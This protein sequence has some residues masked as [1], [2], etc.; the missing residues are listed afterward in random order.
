MDALRNCV[1]LQTSAGEFSPFFSAFRDWIEC[2]QSCLDDVSFTLHV[3]WNIGTW[4][5]H[6]YYHYRDHEFHRVDRPIGDQ[7]EHNVLYR[8]PPNANQSPR[9][10]YLITLFL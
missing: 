5:D 10:T 9:V 1:V 6:A 8:E 4:S 2:N 3:E 7:T